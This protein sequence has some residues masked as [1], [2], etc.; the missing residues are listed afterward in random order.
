MGM[1]QLPSDFSDF[2]RLLNSREADYLII[3]GYA[4]NYHGYSR[5][6][7]DLDIWVGC[8]VAN[9]EK[10][11]S[12][13]RDFGFPDAKAAM[14][15]TPNQVVRMG[16]PPLRLEL[17]TTISGVEFRECFAVRELA[18]IGDITIP[19]LRLDDLKR[20]KRAAA[21]LKDLADLEALE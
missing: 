19:I 15:S 9:A 4:V 3:G 17:L 16:V 12:A 18:D 5:S 8:E 1:I 2:L 20:N 6:T 11:A 10:V 7:G 13:L 14:F 21:R